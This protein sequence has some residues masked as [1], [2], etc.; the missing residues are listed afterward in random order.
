MI[1]LWLSYDCLMIVLWS[2]YDILMVSYDFLCFFLFL[3]IFLW[4]AYGAP[5]V[6]L[7]Y[8]YGVPMV[9]L[10]YY[11]LYMS[12]LWYC[13]GFHMIFQ[14]LSHDCMASQFLVLVY[15]A[16]MLL[17]WLSYVVLYGVLRL[18]Y[19][20]GPKIRTDKPIW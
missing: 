7:W 8:A 10:W 17:F 11:Y 20:H 9:F 1:S 15:V 12:C 3:M 2:S 16:I 18:S 19:E 5:M 6:L 14:R 13:D 4:F